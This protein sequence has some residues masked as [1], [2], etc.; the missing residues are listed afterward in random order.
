MIE[1][2]LCLWGSAPAA[3]F[4]DGRG[5]VR[6]LWWLRP[7]RFRVVP[8]AAGYISGYLYVKDGREIALG[9]DEV[10]W[11]RYPN[12]IEGVCGAL[13]HRRAAHDGGH[14]RGRDPVQPALLPE[15]RLA[16]AGVP[17][18]GRGS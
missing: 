11:F 16:G 8:D 14:E 6:E 5:A 3:V 1:A 12:P 10:V 15:R 9:R 13:A 7:N 2:S 17:E 18:G 4:R